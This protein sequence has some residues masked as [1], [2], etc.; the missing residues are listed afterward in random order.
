[1]IPA[2]AAAALV[3]VTP[4][5]DVLAEID[6]T[7]VATISA[8]AAY[9]VGAPASATVTIQSDEVSALPAVTIAA[10]DPTATEAGTTTGQYTL[11][12]TGATTAALTVNYTVAG[13]ATAGSDYTALPG[14][15]VIPAGVADGNGDGD[16]DQ[17]YGG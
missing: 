1:M 5:D 11:T 10:T 9:T 3:T 2:G 12:R 4:I 8:S 7:V 15:V 6:E 17:R 16:P 13:T 14:S